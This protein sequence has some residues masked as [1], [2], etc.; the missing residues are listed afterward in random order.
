MKIIIKIIKNNV[1]QGLCELFFSQLTF[2]KR[3]EKLNKTILVY[4][5][6]KKN[7]LGKLYLN[8]G[9]NYIENNSP[10]TNSKTKRNINK[11]HKS[12]RYSSAIPI[13]TRNSPS[14]NYYSN[15]YAN[16]YLNTSSVETQINLNSYNS[17]RKSSNSNTIKYS[18]N[19]VNPNLY[20]NFAK[21]KI[22]LD[23]TAINKSEK[24]KNKLDID[25]QV[26]IKSDGFTSLKIEEKLEKE[27]ID[28]TTIDVLFEEENINQL[29]Y[30][31]KRI[32]EFI[33]NL[34]QKFI[35]NTEENIIKS[36]NF[37]EKYCKEFVEK[38][39]D[40]QEIYYDNFNRARDLYNEFKKILI[41]YSENY[42]ILKK[43]T[44]RLNEAVESLK[45]KNE[46][47]NYIN[48]EENKTIN[49]NIYIRKNE[50]NIY[51]TLNGMNYHL[52]DVLKYK[53]DLGKKK[54]N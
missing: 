7:N 26:E 40:L 5:T 11:N 51:K 38:L 32:I 12:I 17:N 1:T 21:N 29:E 3:E 10:Q 53:E 35:F 41:I 47:A 15:T 49:K 19:S 36:D 20:T 13:N 25:K 6:I 43:K 50:M 4:D 9:I 37:L 42:R 52:S 22:I 28:K 48:R 23:N 2:I 24:K 18:I 34:N 45:I 44:N 8:I 33:Y 30:I 31:G 39:F 16:K 54:C 14:Q 46:F 27:D